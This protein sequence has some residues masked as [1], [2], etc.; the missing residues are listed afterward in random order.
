M[1]IRICPNCNTELQ[2]V[3]KITCSYLVWIIDHYEDFE[4]EVFYNCPNCGEY[5]DNED[6]E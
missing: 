4:I 6:F 1:A 3:K 2:K 5:L